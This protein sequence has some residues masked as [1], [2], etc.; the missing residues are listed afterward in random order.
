MQN[1]EKHGFISWESYT[2]HGYN[3]NTPTVKI[4]D[5]QANAIPAGLVMD[6]KLF[7]KADGRVYVIQRN[8]RKHVMDLDAF[9]IWGLNWNAV[10][11]K[12]DAEIDS[13]ADRG[14]LG[15]TRYGTFVG[16]KSEGIK[17]Y[18]VSVDANGNMVRRHIATDAIKNYLTGGTIKTIYWLGDAEFNSIPEGVEY[19]KPSSSL[20]VITNPGDCQSCHIEPT[21]TPTPTATIIPSPNTTPAPIYTRYDVNSDGKTDMADI[22]ATAQ[23][24]GE[25]TN[26]PYPNYDVNQDGEINILDLVLIAQNIL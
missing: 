6:Y 2:S 21:P 25:K 1:G 5:S 23:H 20:A 24:F 13:Y 10:V 9:N 18:Y 15:H 16:Q 17:V 12:S 4:A 19:K 14:E 8:E 7:K 26:T 11:A 3:S 22:A